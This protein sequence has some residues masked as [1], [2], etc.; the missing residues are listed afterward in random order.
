MIY[1]EWV[2]VESLIKELQEYNYNQTKSRVDRIYD[3]LK[4]Q[5]EAEKKKNYRDKNGIISNEDRDILKEVVAAQALLKSIKTLNENSFDE[6]GYHDKATGDLLHA[7]ELM[8]DDDGLLDYTRELRA[9]RRMRREAKDFR[10]ITSPMVDFVN[11]NGAA[12]KDFNKAVQEMR[13]M[14]KITEKRDY[15][16]RVK[17]ELEVAFEKA[18]GN[19]KEE[20]A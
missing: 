4:P 1:E 8:S 14:Q 3:L 16:P 15:Y 10:D 13:N 11:K 12:I 9:T 2:E 17:T 7:L 5:I 18:N 20:S 6:V 19:G